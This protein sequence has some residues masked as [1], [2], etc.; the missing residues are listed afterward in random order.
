MKKRLPLTSVLAVLYLFSHAQAILGIDVSSYQGNITWSQVKNTSGKTFAIAKATEGLTIADAYFVQNETNGTAAGVIMGAYHFAHPET[1][2]AV[3]EANYF[4]S[5]AGP[6]IGPGYFPPSLD[7]EDP[8]T[9]PALSSYFTSAQLTTW[10]QTWMTTVQNATGVKPIIYCNG[11]YASWLGS[12]LNTYGLWSADPDGSSTVAPNAAHLGVWTTWL[13]KQYS[14]TGTVSGI[15]GTGDE[16]MDWYNGTQTQL[17]TL[18]GGNAV[19]P[20]FTANVTVGC[21]GMQVTFT[22][23]STS[24][25]TITGRQ[26]TIT[27]GSPGTSTATNPVVTYNTAGN[28]TVKEVVTSTTGIDSVTQTAYIHVVPDSTL[29]LSQNFQSNT[30]PPPGWTLNFPVAGDSAWEL[31]T[32]NG[33]N[34]THCMYFPANCGY[35]TSTAGQRQQ[36]YTPNYSFVGTTN[37]IM[38]FDV[39]YEPYNRVYSDTLAVYYSLDCANSWNLIY[40]KGGMTLSTTG[41]T[42]SAGVDTSGG[43]GCFIPPNSNAWRSDT[44][45]LSSLTGDADVMFSFESRSGWGNILYR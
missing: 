5:I 32:N 34:S 8:S 40:L 42:D 43:H 1:N 39:A 22:D 28:Y 16:D 41:S 23:H 27:G 13:V 10:V 29:P 17:N 26:W 44:I 21:P 36:L 35:V 38:W 33:Y 24:T 30:F 31:C 6:Y 19:T 7:L 25:G 9:G 3:S 2:S 37:P 45:N 4:V 14:W 18:I 20:S 15:S 12:S 11:N